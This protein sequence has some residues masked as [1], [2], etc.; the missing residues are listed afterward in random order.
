[1]K[2]QSP[3]NSG[4]LK[5][6]IPKKTLETLSSRM[7]RSKSNFRQTAKSS[8]NLIKI[9]LRPNY[10]EGNSSV[11]GGL[12]CQNG[13]VLVKGRIKQRMLRKDLAT[14]KI[15]SSKLSK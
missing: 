14:G 3:K 13:T 5:L 4:A 11:T 12:Q 2:D 15:K 10:Q 9:Y 1:L 7:K 6:S 8:M